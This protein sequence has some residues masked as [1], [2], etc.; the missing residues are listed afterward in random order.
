MKIDDEFNVQIRDRSHDY[1]GGH[2]FLAIT[3]VIIVNV[4]GFLIARRLFKRNINRRMQS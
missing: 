3:V 1:H 4:G 2:L